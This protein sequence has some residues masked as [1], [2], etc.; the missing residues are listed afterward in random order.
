MKWQASVEGKR[1][2]FR[3]TIC[4]VERSTGVYY[5]GVIERFIVHFISLVKITARLLIYHSKIRKRCCSDLGSN[6]NCM[7]YFC[8]S[9]ILT[10]TSKL[11]LIYAVLAVALNLVLRL[12]LCQGIFA[13]M[14]DLWTIG[15]AFWMCLKWVPGWT[16]T[17]CIRYF[18]AVNA[19]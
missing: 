8:F 15:I 7:C 11:T 16:T 4:S 2:L 13:V 5:V 17:I 3:V 9:L 12:L 1:K 14:H 10:T 19:E 18:F 6:H